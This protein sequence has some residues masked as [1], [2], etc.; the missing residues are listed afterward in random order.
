MSQIDNALHKVIE[1]W[2]VLANSVLI[3]CSCTRNFTPIELLKAPMRFRGENSDG[4]VKIAVPKGFPTMDAILVSSGREF[5]SK[6]KDL[7]LPMS[8]QSLNEQTDIFAIK[9][10][11]VKA[12]E[13]L[14]YLDLT[15]YPLYRFHSEHLFFYADN[16]VAAYVGDCIRF[17]ML[18][19]GYQ[20]IIQNDGDQS[21]ITVGSGM[22][23]TVFGMRSLERIQIS[24][25]GRTTVFDIKEKSI[26]VDSL[27]YP[28]VYTAG[29]EMLKTEGKLENMSFSLSDTTFSLKDSPETVSV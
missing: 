20:P 27:M 29:A 19:S 24:D 3:T 14:S 12:L 5:L 13:S 10:T 26:D 4:V 25:S 18:R 9:L 15:Y 21:V 28:S 22:K 7:N 23:I 6:I 8:T 2:I 11:G 1:P 17:I 16:Q